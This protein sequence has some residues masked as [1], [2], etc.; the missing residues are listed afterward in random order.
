VAQVTTLV[1]FDKV[2]VAVVGGVL[3]G[4]GNLVGQVR[5]DAALA[6]SI[7]TVDNSSTAQGQ[8]ATA[9]AVWEQLSANRV[10]HYGVGPKSSSLLPQ[11][12]K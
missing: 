12:K 10:G 11:D 8:V 1:Q 4:D 7:S 3:G 9:L 2:T 5:D 6:K